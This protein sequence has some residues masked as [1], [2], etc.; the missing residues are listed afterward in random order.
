MRVRCSRPIVSI[1]L[2]VL[3]SV[4]GL[5]AQEGRPLELEDYYRLKD[6]GSPALSPDGSRV[7][8][9]VTSVLEEENR[10][11]SG[12]WLVDADGSGEPTRVT[13][14]SFSAS[15]PRWS[16]D[17]RYLVFT[18]NRPDPGGS[19]AGSTWFLRMDR[20]AGEAFRLEG[21]RGS[22]AFSP[23]G[24]WIAFTR[25]TPPPPPA[26]PVWESDFERRTV[27]RFDGREYDWMNY[28]FDRRG[29]L[30]DPRDPN[31]TPPREVY[32]LPAEGGEAWQLT[33]LGFDASGLAWSPDGL[34]LAFTADAHQ[35]D[36]HS[37]ERSDV[38]VVD[39]DGA[40]N[41]LTDD[42]YNYSSPAW[43]ADGARLVVRGNEGLDIIIREARDRGAPS[44]LFVFDAEDGTRLRNLT[45]EWDLIPGGPTVSADGGHVYFSAGI[46]GNTH[47]FRVD[48]GG[49]AVEQV[50][51]GDR[52][53]GSFSFSEDFSRVAFRATAPTE[54]GDVW[55]AG[56]GAAADDEVRL[57][58]VNGDL[59]AGIALSSPERLSFRSRDGTEVEGWMLPARGYTAGQGRFPMV[60]QMHGGPHGAYGNTFSFDQQLLA[61]QGYMVLFTNPRASTGYGEDFRWGTWGGWGFND[62]DDVMAGVDHALDRYEIDTA[63]MGVTGYSY[64]GFLTNW[65]ITQTDRFAAAIAGASISNWVSD[66]GVAD[67]PRTKE[68]EFFGPPWEERGLEHL[69]RSSPIIYAK[70]VTTPT[71]FVHGESDHRVP[72]EEAEQ[73]YVALRKQ[74]VPAKFVRYPDSYHGGWTPWRMVHRMWVQ[75]EWWEQWLRRV[76]S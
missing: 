33:E 73:M 32:L 71:L 45:A 21:L 51:T 50:T 2:A 7:A 29:Y 34:R 40:V 62:Y 1:P 67:I 3:L 70:G 8:Y 57:S 16:P 74:Q 54:P 63:R 64:G 68:S 61:A 72:V 58:E 60:L 9:V 5:A 47:L 19:D 22:P 15:S 28:R 24:R 56:V 25:P 12:I 66:Y 6:A 26:E 36:E 46:R 11:H 31:A 59:L 48:E 75:L 17:G 23:D 65:V 52:R 18:S 35:R 41:R 69:M 4:P 10:R 27:E 76:A 37:Y 49:G 53:L 44:D 20:P 38:W 55:V 14:P 42:G 39:L 43:S 13:S 30:A